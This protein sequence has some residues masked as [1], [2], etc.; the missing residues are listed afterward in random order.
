MKNAGYIAAVMGSAAIPT[1]ARALGADSWQMH[2]WG[3]GYGLWGGCVMWLFLLVIFIFML[4]G[5]RWL[6]LG[7]RF[8]GNESALDILKRRYAQGEISRD[9]YLAMKNDLEQD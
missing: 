6:R 7:G 4:Y 5:G 1:T 9:Q 2:H 3:M 8:T